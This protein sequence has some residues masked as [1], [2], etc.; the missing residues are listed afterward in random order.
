MKKEGISPSLMSG[1]YNRPLNA[2]GSTN[3]NLT[4]PAN[5]PNLNI[6]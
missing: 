6:G 3:M 2:F 5:Y 1:V 4:G